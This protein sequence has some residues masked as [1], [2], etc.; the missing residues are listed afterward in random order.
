MA[1]TVCGRHGLHH[2]ISVQCI[3]S[4]LIDGVNLVS[5]TV[6]AVHEQADSFASDSLQL[7]SFLT[8]IAE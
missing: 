7:C 8:E 2:C 4:H 3:T 1:T 5:N 6:E